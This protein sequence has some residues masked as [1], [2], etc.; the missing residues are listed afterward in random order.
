MSGCH[1]E[2]SGF[3][4]DQVSIDEA[5]ARRGLLSM[6]I[7]LGRRCNFS[8]PYCYASSESDFSDELTESEVRDV[9]DQ[10]QALGAR[11]IIILGGE[12]MIHPRL[13]DTVEFLHSRGLDIDMFTNGTGVTPGA[14]RRLLLNGVNV[15]V[16]MNTFDR[17]VQDRMC[18]HEG[19]YDVIQ[20][21]LKNL[22][23]AG[24][25]GEDNKPFLAISTIMCK[26]NEHELIRLWRWAR[27]RDIL[28]YFELVTP[29][30]MAV[31]TDWAGL[32]TDR[33]RA[34][35]DEIREIDRSQYGHEWSVQPPLVASKCQRHKYSCLV[36]ANGDVMP[37][38]GVTIPVGNIRTRSLADILEDSEVV[39]DLRN[40]RQTIKGPCARCGK[41]ETCYG[42]RGA[43]YNL[44][45]DYLESDPTCWENAERQD[46][47]AC[48]PV[49][50]EPYVPH[51]PPML[52]VDTLVRVGER[53]AETQVKVTSGMPFVG[54]DGT[55]D[56]A[57][58]VEMVAQSMAAL[59]GFQGGGN[60][61]RLEGFLLGV[62]T[63]KIHGS[64][65]VGDVL[66][67]SVF[68]AARFGEFGIVEGVVRKGETVL[69]EGEIKLWH[70]ERAEA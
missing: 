21:A 62:K 4:F 20:E 23:Q 9:I 30:G 49:S 10:A 13:L 5:V 56:Q 59:D 31:H 45:G 11:K 17:E 58:Y 69:A 28:P 34:L 67:I 22:K 55:L 2:I 27:D 3:E 65:T 7:E 35:F 29:Q 47:I 8:C 19:A 1:T 54:D 41:A 57:A 61:R 60:G 38:V 50:V 46:E 48:L 18:G 52:A 63:W 14:A 36:A 37:C 39:Q 26:L 32:D 70:R 15:V 66:D 25:P 64:A 12:P 43:A 40:H 33:A 51:G 53:S 44:T 42:C 6:E 16:K 68:K 24:Y